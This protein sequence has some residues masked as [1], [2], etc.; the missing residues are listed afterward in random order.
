MTA[1]KYAGAGEYHGGIPARD[2]TAEEFAALDKD[3]Q[4]TVKASTLYEAV[5][6]PTEEKAAA[7]EEK[8]KP[9]K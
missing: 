8:P 4:A 1:Y 5:D 7:K 3:Q 6:Q 2:L 9:S